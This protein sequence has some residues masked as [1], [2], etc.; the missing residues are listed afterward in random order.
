MSQ[1]QLSRHLSHK[2][3]LG[4]DLPLAPWVLPMSRH[5]FFFATSVV[6][7]GAIYPIATSNFCRDITFGVQLVHGRSLIYFAKTCLAPVETFCCRDIHS[8]SRHQFSYHSSILPKEGS[9]SG[10]DL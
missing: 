6:S 5:Q 2:L 10:R 3:L 7:L 8:V 1:P 9:S 4:R